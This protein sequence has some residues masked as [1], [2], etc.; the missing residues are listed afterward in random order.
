MG[1]NDETDFSETRYYVLIKFLAGKEL[2]SKKFITENIMKIAFSLPC[3][4]SSLR[5]LNLFLAKAKEL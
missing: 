5:I 1:I 3:R 4:S 2:C